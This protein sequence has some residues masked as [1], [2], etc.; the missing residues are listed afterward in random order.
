[1]PARFCLPLRRRALSFGTVAIAGLALLVGGCGK[2][3]GKTGGG[4][5]HDHHHHAHPTVGPHKGTI[6]EWGNNH[7]H[8]L[9]LVIDRE[10]QQATVYFLDHDMKKS[11][12]TALKNGEVRII[13]AENSVQIPLVA[14]PLEGETADKASRYVGTHAVLGSKEPLTGDVR[15]QVGTEH[16]IESFEKVGE[17]NAA[18]PADK[19]AEVAKPDAHEGHDHEGHE[20]GAHDEHA[21]EAETKGADKGADKKDAHDD[22]AHE[23]HGA[24]GKPAE[25][26][27]DGEPPNADTEKDDKHG[28]GHEH[29]HEAH[30][31]DHDHGAEANKP[32]A[33]V[34]PKA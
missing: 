20:D 1:M 8:H 21:R 32:A 28:E 13:D 34:A 18:T 16:Y 12:A 7:E 22:H 31:H 30:D 10:K 9:E 11:E 26:K 17:T 4:D 27:K 19:K 24:E 6:L 2:P 29:D 25:P 3:D 14:S 33:D 5:D 23:E 15:G